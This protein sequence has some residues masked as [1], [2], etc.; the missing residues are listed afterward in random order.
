MNASPRQIAEAFSRHDFE[1]AYPY[2]ADA[3]RWNVVGGEVITGKTNVV[4][5]CQQTTRY[6]AGVQVAL[7]SCRV[8]VG[9]TCVV[10]DSLADYTD[11][12]QQTS[13]VASCDIYEFAN[14]SV[15]EIT[16]YT[17]EIPLH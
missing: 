8:I 13:K 6:L 2:L 12:Q 7:L 9:E 10:V 3:I 16:S 15:V 4:T 1:T 14:G 11:S 5:A 17:V